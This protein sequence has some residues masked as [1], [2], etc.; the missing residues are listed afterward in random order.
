M[1]MP[2]QGS[3]K[4]KFTFSRLIFRPSSADPQS[5]DPRNSSTI[6]A[7]LLNFRKPYDLD[8]AT[9]GAAS[10]RPHLARDF[11]AGAVEGFVQYAGSDPCS[12]KDRPLRADAFRVRE[13]S[14]EWHALRPRSRRTR[15]GVGAQPS[16]RITVTLCRLAAGTRPVPTKAQLIPFAHRIAYDAA[17][18]IDKSSSPATPRRL[19]NIPR[20]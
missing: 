10:S 7:A 5:Q 2:P 19:R 16:D 20:S 18:R 6:P 17:G 4:D 9:P 12:S 1:S 15:P 14:E 3:R 8:A 11:V 13:T